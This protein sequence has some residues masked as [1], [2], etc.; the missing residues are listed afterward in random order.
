MTSIRIAALAALALSAGAAFAQPAVSTDPRVGLAPGVHDA[1]TAAMGLELVGH[2]AKPTGFFNPEDM[3]DFSYMNSD[4]AFSGNTLFLGSFHGLQVYDISD[5]TSPR[6][7]A[8]LECPGGQ[9]DVSVHG[10]LLFMSVEE[11]RGRV[12]CG[13]QGVEAPAS[14]ERFRGVRVYDVSDVAR[15]RQVAAVQTCRGSHTHTLVPDPNDDSHVYLYVSG[16]SQVRPG[17]ELAG[18]LTAGP[19]DPTSSL[20][21]I[22]VIEVPLDNPERAAIVESPRFLVGLEPAP[23]HGVTAQ[24]R[25]AAAA[26]VAA[27]RERGQFALVQDGA[28]IIVPEN[29]VRNI[30]DQFVAQ[31]GGTGEPTA[32]DTTA[33]WSALE[34][35]AAQQGA[36]EGE[37]HGPDQCHDITVFPEVGLGAGACGGY[38]ILLDLSDLSNPRR[39]DAAA[40]SNFA[41]WHSATFSDD[42]TK[43]VFTDEWGGGMAPRCRATDS[44]QWGA[45]AIF[46]IENRRLVFD[47]YYKLPAPQTAQENC[48]AHNGSIIPVPGRDLMVQGWYQGGTSIFDFTDP[49]NPVEVAYFDRGPLF[50][51]RMAM[52]GHWGAYWY[53][54][55]VYASEIGRGLDVFRLV[56]TEHLDASDISAAEAVHMDEFNPQTQEQIGAR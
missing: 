10:D 12:D 49:D 16:T 19:D 52:A 47:D 39:I 25:A 21:R 4:M 9:G 38:G 13:P 56:P 46:R 37:E 22:E 34:Q 14:P 51:D 31:R 28:A 23:E 26:E 7:R 33:L 55:H 11:P 44:P 24:D 45:N 27:A 8:T 30:L 29:M 3:G 40:D 1:G 2:V 53:N 41:Y 6:L 15:P 17:E 42:G 50:G 43:V 5:P 48:V 32:A 54:G 35:M 20:F 18:C 36:D